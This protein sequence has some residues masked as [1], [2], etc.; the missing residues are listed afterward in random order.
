MLRSYAVAIASMLAG[1]S[2]VHAIYKPDLTIPD[3]D[4]PPTG[5]KEDSPRDEAATSAATL[6]AAQGNQ[7]GKKS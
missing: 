7:Q 6:A 2:V 5:S 3:L 4:A 1:A